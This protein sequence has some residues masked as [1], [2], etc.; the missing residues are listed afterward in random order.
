MKKES[1]KKIKQTILTRFALSS[2]LTLSSYA[3]NRPTTSSNPV[4]LRSKTCSRAATIWTKRLGRLEEDET[5]T[6]KVIDEVEFKDVAGEILKTKYRNFVSKC[7]ERNRNHE[8]NLNKTQEKGVNHEEGTFFMMN[9]TEETIFMNEEKYTPPKSESNASEEDDVWY[10]DNDASNHMTEEEAN[11]HSSSVIVHETNLESK[12]YNSRSDDTL[13]PLVRLET[14][15]LLIALVAE[16][17]WKIHHLNMKMDFINGDRKKLDSTLK[18]MG[19]LQCMHEKAI[20]RKRMASQ[21]EM[22]DFGE[23]TYY[24][25]IK[26]SQGKDCIEIKQERYALKILIEAGMEDCNPSLCPTEPRLMLSKEED[27]PEV[28][29]TQYL[30]MVSCL[31]Y[32]LHTR[33]DLTYS[34]G[35]VSRYMQSVTPPN[36]VAAE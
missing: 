9:H 5:H 18:E 21:F 20:Y 4:I 36:G 14:I 16:K 13:N 19:F 34:V 22:L 2:S 31:R 23:L 15:R 28:E 8:F 10:F 3:F 1:K 7:P 27:E 6:L 11:P 25:G 24:L 29:A 30:K 17:E 35:V 12:E 26:V 32:L 33:P